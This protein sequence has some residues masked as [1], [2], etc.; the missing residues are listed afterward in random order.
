MA[1]HG[2]IRNAQTNERTNGWTDARRQNKTQKT[3]EKAVALSFRPNH[4][5]T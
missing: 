2:Q 1:P 5:S 4:T 3:D